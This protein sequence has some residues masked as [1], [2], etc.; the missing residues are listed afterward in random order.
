MIIAFSFNHNIIKLFCIGISLFREHNERK[1][2]VY[3]AV[4]PVALVKQSGRLG[5]NYKSNWKVSLRD[6]KEKNLSPGFLEMLGDPLP[7]LESK[8]LGSS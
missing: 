1:I 6:R 8:N 2:Q 4:C 3:Q 7:W 5:L